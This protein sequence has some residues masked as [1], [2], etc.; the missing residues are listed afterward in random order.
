MP[1]DRAARTR[2][3]KKLSAG[4]YAVAV[5]LTNQAKVRATRHV[6]TGERRN[7][8][9]QSQLP[10]GSVL[11]GMPG[12]AKNA[13]L[14]L[15]F[16]PHWVP[17]RH[18]EPWM[19]RNRVGT[20]R[21]AASSLKTRRRTSRVAVVAAGVYVG[22]PNSRLDFGGGGTGGMRRR[23]NRSTYQ[24]WQT[25]GARSQYLTPG[26]VGHSVLRWT[27]GTRLRAVAPRAFARGYG[28]G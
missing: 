11:W 15:G 10:N 4:L 3:R 21:V 22:G 17:L 18:I 5:E 7:S 12:N 9:T 24:R 27:V 8:I 28:R 6:D 23:G 13:A 2:L 19:R 25:K 16:S 20:Q 1:I 26:K 14:E